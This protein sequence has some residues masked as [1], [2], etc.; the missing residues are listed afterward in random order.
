MHSTRDEKKYDVVISGMGPAGLAT[1]LELAE[2]GKSVLIISNR[3]DNFTR[4]R[5]IGLNEKSRWYLYSMAPDKAE[6]TA[7]ETKFLALIDRKGSNVAI[8]NVEKYLR[9]QLDRLKSSGKQIDYLFKSELTEVDLE[10]GKAGVGPVEQNQPLTTKNIEFTYLIG[11]DG[12]HRHAFK[13]LQKTQQVPDAVEVIHPDSQRVAANHAIYNLIIER[14]DGEPISLPNNQSVFVDN[15]DAIR[16]GLFMKMSSYHK[17]NQISVQAQATTA[18]PREIEQIED[19]EERKQAIKAY[20]IKRAHH[21]LA[22]IGSPSI[23]YKLKS[24][25]A[26]NTKK[27]GKSFTLFK[28]KR[29]E[30]SQAAIELNNHYFIAVGDSVHDPDYRVG[31]GLPNAIKDACSVKKIV[32]N[33]MKVAAYNEE[34]IHRAAETR[35]KL[36]NS[37]KL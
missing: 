19:E 4:K 11:A 37:L 33:K 5:L 6:R 29:R 31:E 24:I 7:E 13:L 14:K 18:Y 15:K 3:E 8:K 16:F 28:T 10:N 34:R 9:S 26:D 22:D 12:V 30:A 32:T 23:E 36:D 25:S 17:S 1:A 2:E 20:I 21:I 27:P 35:N